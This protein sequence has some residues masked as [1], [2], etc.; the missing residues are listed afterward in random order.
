MNKSLLLSVTAAGALA[1]AGCDHERLDKGHHVDTAKAAADIKA[2]EAQW[3]KDYAAKNANALTAH[4]ADDATLTEPG[5]PPSATAAERR[6]AIVAL[7]GDP[8]FSL[9]FSADRVEVAKSGDLAYSRGPFTLGTTDK[10]TG[11]PMTVKGTYLT[12]WQKRDNEWKAVEDVIV[13]GPAAT[14][15]VPAANAADG[16][17]S[18]G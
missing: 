2:Q 6:R 12:V 7:I 17:N 16:G 15:A 14:P 10:A 11:K 1:L 4:Y 9:T 3:Q 18:T 8:N 13:P 5:T